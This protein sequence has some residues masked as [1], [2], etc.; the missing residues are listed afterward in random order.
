MRVVQTLVLGSNC[1]AVRQLTI[2]DQLI[3]NISFWLVA[4]QT[5]AEYGA[6]PFSGESWELSTTTANHSPG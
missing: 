4:C 1:L 6:V 3:K 5:V 2:P